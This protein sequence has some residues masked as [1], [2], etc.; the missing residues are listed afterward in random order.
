MTP[1]PNGIKALNPAKTSVRTWSEERERE[2]K[3]ERERK[4]QRKREMVGW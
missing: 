1:H 2:M 4:R 3:R